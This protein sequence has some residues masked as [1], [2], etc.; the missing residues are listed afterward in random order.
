MDSSP[1]LF[2]CVAPDDLRPQV[3]PLSGTVTVDERRASLSD[4]DAAAVEHALRMGEAWGLAV[5]AITVGPPE[6]EVA[7]AEISA[8]GVAVRRVDTAGNGSPRSLSPAEIAGDPRW[9]AAQLAAQIRQAGP[10]AMVVCGDRS[11]RHGVGAVPGLLAAELRMPHA[12]GL[13]AV[14]LTGYPTLRVDKRLEGGWRERIVVASPSVLSVEAAGVRLRRADLR[15]LVAAPRNVAEVVPAV[16]VQLRGTVEFATPGPYRP[17][18]LRVAPPDGDARERLVALAGANVTGS[19]NRV[20]GPL[21]P[22]EATDELIAFLSGHGYL[23]GET[24]PG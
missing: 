6:W 9:V 2:V 22:E 19:T 20:I 21:D 12:L 23:A 5:V 3:D 11:A 24:V 14:E 15:S 18:A 4:S 17:R 10:A 8:L 16:E 13:V 7:L 1:S